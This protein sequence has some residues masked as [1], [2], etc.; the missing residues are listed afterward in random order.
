M[1]TMKTTLNLE[2]LASLDACCDGF[3]AFKQHHGN[4]DVLLSEG[5]KSNGWD[6]TWWYIDEAWSGF[7]GQQQKDIHML[8]CKWAL[9]VIDNF[10]KEFP[11]DKRPRQAI[12]AKIKWLDWEVSDGELLVANEAAWEAKEAAKEEESA[13]ESAEYAAKAALYTSGWNGDAAEHVAQVA[14]VS[15]ALSFTEL[16]TQKQQDLM[17]LFLE[18]EAQ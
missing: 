9:S 14:S 15:G 12:E 5:L 4:K 6:D 8:G 1:S 11:N 2:E 13:E 18:W 10:E 3:E 7:S 16:M 17:N